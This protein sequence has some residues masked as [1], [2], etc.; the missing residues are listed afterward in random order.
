MSGVCYNF[1]DSL[2]LRN[3]QDL[4][5][6][7]YLNFLKIWK[8]KIFKC[9]VKSRLSGEEVGSENKNF[10]LFDEGN[11]SRH[12]ISVQYIF[13]SSCPACTARQTYTFG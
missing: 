1:F 6:S 3:I 2:V 11:K 8:V 12:S 5:Y 9:P 7:K 13:M 10:S 4:K